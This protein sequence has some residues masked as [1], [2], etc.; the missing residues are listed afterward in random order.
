MNFHENQRNFRVEGSMNK[1]FQFQ[2]EP[3]LASSTLKRD[4][5]RVEN[6]KSM[7]NGSDRSNLT[8]IYANIPLDQSSISELLTS[9]SEQVFSRAQNR[10]SQKSNPSESQIQENSRSTNPY[11]Y[12][13]NLRLQIL[14]QLL[15][16]NHWIK[17]RGFLHQ[18]E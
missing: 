10:S 6:L 5:N 8:R 2:S 13:E 18:N 7:E 14:L 17:N 1:I 15:R 16:E 12:L 9:S 3:P 11:H 4:P